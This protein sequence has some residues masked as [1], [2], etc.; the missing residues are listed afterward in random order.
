M[1]DIPCRTAGLALALAACAAPALLAQTTEQPNLIFTISAGFMAGSG[2][3]WSVPRQLAKVPLNI[4][5]EFDTLALSRSLRAGF[6]ASLSAS[7]FRSPHLGL[8][9]EVGFFGMGTV[10]ACAPVVPYKLDSENRNQK[11]CEYLQGENIRGNAVGFLG[12]LIYRFT[13]RG[14]QPFVRASAGPAYLGSS[15]VEMAAP[16]V[17]ST[18]SGP[19]E[20]LWFFFTERSQKQFTWMVSLGAGATLPLAPGYQ[21]RFEARD[22]IVPLPIAAGAAAPDTSLDGLPAFAPVGTRVMHVPTISFGLD[23]VLERRRGRR[24]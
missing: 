1:R 23:V 24:Y 4:G 10:A 15:Y 3:L 12:G 9:A 14:V 17:T 19:A 11:A 6:S 16:I 8:T 5:Y 2:E 22:M 20:T 7:Y 21:L 18:T 13:T